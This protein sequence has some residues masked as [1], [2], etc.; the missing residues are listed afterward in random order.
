VTNNK[1]RLHGFN[2]RQPRDVS[3]SSARRMLDERRVSRFAYCATCAYPACDVSL[4]YLIAPHRTSNSATGTAA[5]DHSRQSGE[6][7]LP[8]ASV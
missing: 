7:A 6:D 2:A 4:P 1:T 5:G 3:R 8:Q